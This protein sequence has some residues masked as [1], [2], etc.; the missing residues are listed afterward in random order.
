M[1]RAVLKP[2]LKK[3][4]LRFYRFFSLVLNAANRVR[5]DGEWVVVL[6]TFGG[7]E[8]SRELHSLG[9]KILLFES[10]ASQ[11]NWLY[12]CRTHFTGELNLE[13]VDRIVEEA[14]A[15][16]CAFVMM[17][18]DDNLIPIYAEVNRKLDNDLRFSDTAVRASA[19]KS[20]MRARLASA[21]LPVACGGS[22]NTLNELDDLPL[23]AVIKP[24][25]GQ[26]SLGVTLVQS[27]EEAELAF[28]NI[29]Q[30]LGEICCVFEEFLLGRQFDVEGIVV[31]GKPHIH[32]ITEECYT[33]FLPA[34]DRPSWYLHSPTLTPDLE[35]EI[36][37]GAM[38]ALAACDLHSGAFHVEMKIKNGKAIV[39]DLANR[40]GA[41]FFEYT[42]RSTGI[43]AI[44]ECLKSMTPG[45][46]VAE[47][48]KDSAKQAILRFY[49]YQDRPASQAILMEAQ[50]LDSTKQATLQKIGEELVLIAEEATLRRFLSRTTELV[51][52]S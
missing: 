18:R 47:P 17:E 43:P 31:D 26:G 35:S 30:D 51:S 25:F 44:H 7:K 40:M 49:N 24:E 42:K 36:R 46:F 38:A 5:C 32:M 6:A 10:C 20:Y 19:S 11:L 16:G 33:D 50:M 39:I 4:I 23:P 29:R 21:G 1:Y 8:L 48:R 9:Y 14:R 22:I 3:I 41:D 37:H 45:S 52:E 12:A 27:R 13:H 34:F 2:L 15:L 28:K